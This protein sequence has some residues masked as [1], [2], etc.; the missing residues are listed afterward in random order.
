MVYFPQ[1]TF[2]NILEYCDDRIEQKQRY[3]WS[4]I[5]P[6]RFI[7]YELETRFK[8]EYIWCNYVFI[9]ELSGKAFDEMGW[10]VYPTHLSDVSLD[11]R[12]DDCV[13]DDLIY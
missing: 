2:S 1:E 10:D 8:D 5:K 6:G 12:W 3:L 11:V 7:T 9:D 4:K 13:S